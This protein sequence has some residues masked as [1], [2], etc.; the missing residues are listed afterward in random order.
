M[1]GLGF[2]GDE[3]GTGNLITTEGEGRSEASNVS[4][5]RA[6]VSELALYRS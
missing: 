2:D 1:S 4:G 5:P 3:G 6:C